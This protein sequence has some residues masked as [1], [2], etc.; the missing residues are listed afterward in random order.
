MDSSRENY[1]GGTWT[2]ARFH[3]FV[4]STLRSGSRRWPP[5]FTCL[6]E[7]K[8][9]K[10]INVKTGRLAQHYRCA[11]CQQEFTNKDV[12]VDHIEPVVDPTKGFESW[13]KFVHGLFCEQDNLQVLCKP[14]HKEKS[15]EEKKKKKK[16]ES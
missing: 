9:E 4:A 5:K 8:T 12:Q 1:N 15:L 13:D 2:Y 16:N 11:S 6:N 7:A 3:S 14:C 10:K